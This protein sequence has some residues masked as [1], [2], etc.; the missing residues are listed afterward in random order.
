[1]VEGRGLM[2]FLLKL[3]FPFQ[4]GPRV[5]AGWAGTPSTYNERERK[6]EDWDRLSFG[7]HSS[8]KWEPPLNLRGLRF[9]PHVPCTVTSPATI[10]SRSTS[11]QSKFPKCL[12]PIHTQACG[13]YLVCL[14]MFS[15]FYKLHLRN[16]NFVAW[17]NLRWISLSLYL[18][19]FV[20]FSFYIYRGLKIGPPLIWLWL[21]QV[22][23]RVCWFRNWIHRSFQLCWLLSA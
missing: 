1:M 11:P 16:K 2:L 8:K 19:P 14:F 7:H 5:Q 12:G 10:D 22:E 17:A 4:C 3:V 20:P 18:F 13:C 23:V 21:V 9:L 15:D 6:R